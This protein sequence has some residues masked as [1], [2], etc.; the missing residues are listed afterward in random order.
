MCRCGYLTTFVKQN[1][2]CFSVLVRVT[3]SLGLTYPRQHGMP[4]SW[5]E[6]HGS[7]LGDII[8][9]LLAKSRSYRCRGLGLQNRRP[10]VMRL[11]GGMLLRTNGLA[12]CYAF[13]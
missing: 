1:I 6:T 5:T 12:I 3:S 7:A 11:R 4:R 13:C 9:T 10:R 8:Q 2:P